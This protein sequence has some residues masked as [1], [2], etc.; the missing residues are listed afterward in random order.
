LVSRPLVGAVPAARGP[1]GAVARA[2]AGA[3]AADPRDRRIAELEAELAAEKQARRDRELAWLAY[4]RA[5]S[6][7]DIAKIVG[8][9]A[10]DEAL[11][12]PETPPVAPADT[13]TAGGE[14]P[15]V[16]PDRAAEIL[17]SLRSL[18]VLE[19]VRGLDLLEVGALGPRGVGPVVFR[20][21]DDR[22]RLTGSLHADLLRLEASRAARTLALVLEG[23]YEGRGGERTPFAGGERRIVL[24]F[25][26]PSPWM[27]ELPELFVAAA[28]DPPLD[29]GRW[30]LDP[31]RRELNRLLAL[32][33]STGLYRVWGIGGVQADVLV[34]VQ[35]EHYDAEGRVVERFFA[36]R[37]TIRLEPPG[38]L[39]LLEGGAIVQG[40]EKRAFLEGRYRLFFPH[41]PLAEWR[42]ARVP[43]LAGGEEAGG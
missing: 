9:F 16:L 5:L 11:L 29:D 19:E 14:A 24:P 38:V 17:R 43:G 8:G 35:I 42:A 21:L 25:V 2:G 30:E 7:L 33:V 15:A 40:T 12:P 37:A 4:N 3:A 32:D 26:D 36:D 27:E 23:G 34:D 28:L 20:T 31:L 1:A 39:L 18:L 41:A 22:G 6:D 13:A 10:V